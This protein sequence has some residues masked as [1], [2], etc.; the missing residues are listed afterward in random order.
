MVM[1]AL[2]RQIRRIGIH[3]ESEEDDIPGS[4]M[5]KVI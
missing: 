1:Q 2:Q 5:N 3:T 4:G